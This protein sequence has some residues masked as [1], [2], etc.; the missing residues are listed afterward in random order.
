M[1]LHDK[2]FSVIV[3]FLIGILF[4]SVLVPF[5]HGAVIVVCITLFAAAGLAL[6][7]RTTLAVLS[8]CILLGFFYFGF[9]DRVS[10]A[11]VIPFDTKTTLQAV[12]IKSTV[13]LSKQ[14]VVLRLE[15]PLRGNVCATVDR[16]PL[17]HYGDLVSF[18]GTIREPDASSRERLLKDGVSGVANFPKITFI[19]P[20]HGVWIKE[21][22]LRIKSFAEDA[23]KRALPPEEAAFLSG[24]TLGDTGEFSKEFKQKMSVTGTSH[25]VALSGYNISIVVNNV[26][27]V[28]ALFFTRRITFVLGTLAVVLFVVMTGAEASVVRAAI[29]ASIVLLA[30]QVGRVH[31]VRNAI[32]VAAFLMILA[33]PRLLV[34]DVGFTLSFAAI[35]GL[36]YV[37]PA[38]MKLF[39]I[40]R[41]PGFLAWR[42]NFWTTFSAQ[43]A[44]LPI[45]LSIFGLFSPISL[46]TNILILLVIPFTMTLGFMMVAAAAVAPFLAQALGFVTHLFLRYE[47][48][49]IEWFSHFDIALR[50]AHFGMILS[51]IYYA[52]L[53]ALVWMV[54]KKKESHEIVF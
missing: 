15:Q 38:L 44:V 52:F 35:I 28:L 47:M 13:G 21:Q 1:P 7:R 26:M 51:V 11:V 20:H 29:M 23:F 22:L 41:E 34:W 50:V 12:V 8:P 17:F 37:K 9:F 30:D 19:E 6:F 5:A 4:A 36:V 49:V 54:A 32:A 31:S 33:N 27:L 39:R 24:L 16:Y 46:L 3:F 42:E 53:G 10:N 14:D 18:L 25:I 40:R 48:G 45:L 43:I 2:A